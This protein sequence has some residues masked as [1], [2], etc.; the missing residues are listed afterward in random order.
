MRATPD[1]DAYVLGPYAYAYVTIIYHCEAMD[2]IFPMALEP[3]HLDLCSSSYSQGSDKRS[4]LTALGKFCALIFG[5]EFLIE[6][7][8]TSR[9]VQH[10][11]SPSTPN[12]HQ[13]S[14]RPRSPAPS[15]LFCPAPFGL[16]RPSSPRAL[17]VVTAS[18]LRR[19]SSLLSPCSVGTPDSSFVCSPFAVFNLAVNHHR[20][21]QP[22]TVYRLRFSAPTPK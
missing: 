10:E 11:S 6:S 9:S 22:R 13:S 2:V 17:S 20:R 21:A 14:V 5:C 19:H 16:V 7:L 15:G 8:R 12:R 4:G 18:L 3:S 1:L